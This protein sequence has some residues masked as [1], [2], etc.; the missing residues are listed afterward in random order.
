MSC[1]TLNWL[2]S[3]EKPVL[4]VGNGVLFNPVP[5]QDY[6][7]VVR[8]NNYVLGGLSGSKVTHWVAN[9]YPDIQRRDHPVVLVPWTLNLEER[10]GCPTEPFIKR[11]AGIRIVHPSDD[12]HIR[13]WFPSATYTGK[14]FPTTGFCF[15]ALL[16]R[17]K[18][19][20]DIIG[21][22]GMRTGH[23]GNPAF[24]HGHTRT[25]AKEMLFINSWG[26]KRR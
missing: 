12:A 20:P 3:L 18:I 4:V 23:Q 9:G 26:L 22:D 19:K 17:N 5:E 15:L 21:F 6:P 10:R 16:M 13:W 8:I 14:T 24:G 1:E 2:R 25:C 7:T 11:M